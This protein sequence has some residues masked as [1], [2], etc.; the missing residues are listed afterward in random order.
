MLD[1][2]YY[3]QLCLSL[4]REY[5]KLGGN[6]NQAKG[7][8]FLEQAFNNN[9]AADGMTDKKS[10]KTNNEVMLQYYIEMAA[11]LIQEGKEN[12]AIE[13]HSK[14]LH[15][16]KAIYGDENFNTLECYLNLAQMYEKKGMSAEADLMFTECLQHFDK[17]DQEL[18]KKNAIGGSDLS[19]SLNS[20]EG[21]Y[22]KKLFQQQQKVFGGFDMSIKEKDASVIQRIG[23]YFREKKEYERAC[24]LLERVLEVRKRQFIQ[25]KQQAELK[26]KDSQ[27]AETP[28][29]DDEDD[30]D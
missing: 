30:I 29:L 25:K 27:I 1:N 22:S 26:N 4:A 3:S 14:A 13:C 28:A 8:F 21:G 10:N 9:Q 15:I 12:Q 5:R 17:K 11:I 16:S 18:K 6:H 19:G 20:Q 24:E 2:H 7:M 23:I